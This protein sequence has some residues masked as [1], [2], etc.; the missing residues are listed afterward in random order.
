MKRYDLTEYSLFYQTVAEMVPED[1][2]EWVRHDEAD[3]TI[4]ELR[5]LLDAWCESYEECKAQDG[6][7]EHTKAA[8]AK[9]KG[10]GK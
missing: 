5:Q 1:D 6:I 3:A 4:A 7:F 10:V 8:I 2:G 9:H